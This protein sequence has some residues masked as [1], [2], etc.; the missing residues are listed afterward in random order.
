MTNF[1]SLKS[2]WDGTG[3]SGVLIQALKDVPEEEDPNNRF[4]FSNVEGRLIFL[5]IRI[6]KR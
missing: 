6:L 2:R 1:P 5:K 3:E 4:L